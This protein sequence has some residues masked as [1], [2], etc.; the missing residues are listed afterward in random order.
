MASTK[1]RHIAGTQYDSCTLYTREL[2]A[3]CEV[4]SKFGTVH[5]DILN[6]EPCER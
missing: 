2:K 4:W 1:S 5:E 6:K 3:S